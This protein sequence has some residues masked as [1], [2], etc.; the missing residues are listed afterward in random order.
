[1]VNWCMRKG[2]RKRNQVTLAQRLLKFNL[3]TYLLRLL[4]TL[5]RRAKVTPETEWLA[6]GIWTIM[7]PAGEGRVSFLMLHK[8]GAQ[9]GYCLLADEYLHYSTRPPHNYLYDGGRPHITTTS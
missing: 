5:K 9:A 1:M 8:E 6:R 3:G 2:M 7:R 4:S